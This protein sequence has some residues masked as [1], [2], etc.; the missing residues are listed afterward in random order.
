M[1]LFKK[2]TVYTTPP[3]DVVP[4]RSG[5]G[6]VNFKDVWWTSAYIDGPEYPAVLGVDSTGY[7]LIVDLVDAPHMLVAGTTGSGKSV[8]LNT[9][10]CGL[11][12]KL[13]PVRLRFV[14][15]DPKR[16][17]LSQ[18]KGV[19]HMERP[20]I[21]T[22]DEAVEALNQ[23]VTVMEKRYAQME[24]R[25]LK[26][27]KG[28]ELEFP[29]VVVVVDE[30][31]DLMLTAKKKIEAP[32]VRL[33]QLGRAAGIHLI[34]ATQSPRKDVLTGLIKANVPTRV[35]LTTADQRES[36]VILDHGG[37]EKL[38]GRGQGTLKMPA[39]GG[40]TEFRAAWLPD[41]DINAICDYWRR[42]PAPSNKV[43]GR[44]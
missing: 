8:L 5:N 19:P 39:R 10:I 1:G 24:R 35:A 18:Y 17:E 32:I 7:P 44:W 21:K 37:A 22:A 13:T 43:L 3:G 26:N 15:I 41:G 36:L 29:R 4:W 14:M 28:L 2:R 34:I 11:L 33:A 27:V 20:P 23:L 31:A 25:G 40:E 6:A 12:V 9:I 30:F 42:Y 16:V 38:R